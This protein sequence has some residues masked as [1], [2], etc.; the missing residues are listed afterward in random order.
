[1]NIIRRKD[2]NYEGESEMK[3]K[4]KQLFCV[5][6]AVILCMGTAVPAAAATR[7]QRIAITKYKAY[8]KKNKGWYS[9]V[10]IDKNGIPE[11]VIHNRTKMTN[12]LYTYNPRTRRTVCLKRMSWGKDWAK[13]RYSVSRHTVIF[14]QTDT[15]GYRYY[16]YRVSGTKAKLALR[17]EYIN[18]RF[19]RFGAKYKKGYKVNGKRVSKSVYNKKLSSVTRGGRYPSKASK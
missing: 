16:A 7:N 19:V 12:E 2:I 13:P 11:L 3:K 8:L 18:G 9:M 15:G 4:L 6:L 5:M 1:M 14:P 17:T 10:D